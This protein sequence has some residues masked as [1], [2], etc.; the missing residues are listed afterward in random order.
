V[1]EVATIA[2][3]VA[4]GE[5]GSPVIRTSDAGMEIVAVL[6]SRSQVMAQPIGLVTPVQ[7]RIDSVFEELDSVERQP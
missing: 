5:S 4:G 6:S 7:L 1:P 3:E 2:C